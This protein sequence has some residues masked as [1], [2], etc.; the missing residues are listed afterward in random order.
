MRGRKLQCP[1]LMAASS[2]LAI[3]CLEDRCAWWL[4]RDECCAVVSIAGIADELS[5]L[6]QDVS[7]M[8]DRAR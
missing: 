7:N 5:R 4:R 3:D 1:M 6:Q 8:A 2:E